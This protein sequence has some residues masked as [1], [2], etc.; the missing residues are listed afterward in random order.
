MTPR[1]R[2][3]PTGLALLLWAMTTAPALAQ[4]P[5]GADVATFVNE[6]HRAC[7]RGDKAAM[8]GLVQYPL[9]VSTSGMR[10]PIANRDALLKSYEAVFTP[11]VC[12]AIAAAQSG[13]KGGEAAALKATANGISIGGSVVEASRVNGGLKVV[14][15]S[16]GAAPAAG[17]AGGTAYK[18]RTNERLMPRPGQVMPVRGALGQGQRESFIVYAAQGQL[19]SVRL[20][21]VQPDEVIATIVE[22]DSGEPVDA[23]AGA[24][25]RAW[26]G[27]VK[28][29]ADYRIQVA[30][31][32]GTSQTLG[33]TVSVQ[34]K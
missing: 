29:S 34:V 24:G 22:A 4:A 12:E 1:M 13:L 9:S 16:A 21:E 33:Y 17:G 3:I 8:A 18:L 20:T 28:K 30:R 27:R 25:V 19:L 5:A 14:R 26:N 32:G 31:T 23:R 15:I 10:I 6:L 11:S 2:I 7:G